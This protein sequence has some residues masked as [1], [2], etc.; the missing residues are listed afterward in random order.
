M[1]ALVEMVHKWSE[2]TDKSGTFV[3]VLF[4]DYSKAFDL[5]NHELL[6]TKLVEVGLPAHLVRWLAAFLIN[7]QQVVKIGDVVS[8]TGYPKGGVPQG[9]LSGPNNLLVHTNDLQTQCPMYKYVDDITAF[10]ICNNDRVSMLQ[11]SVDVIANWTR[12]NYMRVNTKKT[13]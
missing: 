6:I 9:T 10:D 7:R 8:N 12:D 11:Q 1:I 3:R 2:A 13:K 4:I 5:V